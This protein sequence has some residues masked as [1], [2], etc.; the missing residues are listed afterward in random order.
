M[1][2]K[3]VTLDFDGQVAIL[4][5]DHQE[6]MN[7]V[8]VDMLGGLAE[9]MDEIADRRDDVLCLV[10]TGAGRAFCTGANLQG[11]NNNLTA[12]RSNAGA[13]LETAFHPF[14]RRLQNL[15]CPI[16][17][18]VNG[19]AAGAGMSFALMGDLVLCAKSSYF[20]QAFRRIGLVPD[21]GSTYLLPRLVGKARAMEMALL[22]EKIPAAR[23]LDWGLINRCVPDAELMP[24]ALAL[25]A[26]LAA[27]PRSL[28]LI[29][30]AI[31][32][33]LDAGWT[34]QLQAER[35]AQKLAGKTDDFIEG[36]GAFLQKR[37]AAFKGR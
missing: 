25:A 18:A 13:T 10:I 24:T 3:H 6:V 23:A 9:A 22:G 2:F 33:S 7:A 37:P 19:P 5:L 27:G 21:G 16:V 28:G 14:L 34:E 11:R 26:E 31:W 36:V 12:K 4:K 29:R 8:S 20:L 35:A 17:T 30:R 32:D 15:H 1:Q